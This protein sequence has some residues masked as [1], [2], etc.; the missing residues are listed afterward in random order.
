MGNPKLPFSNSGEKKR[1]AVCFKIWLH[2]FLT[3]L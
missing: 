3:E 1:G 2:L